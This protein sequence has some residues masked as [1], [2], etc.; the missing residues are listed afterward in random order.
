M[1]PWHDA[2]EGCGVT[3]EPRSVNLQELQGVG[4][5][6]IEAAASVHQ[7]LGESGVADDWVDD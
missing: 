1:F 5:E 7:H 4:I 3:S 6:V 2:V